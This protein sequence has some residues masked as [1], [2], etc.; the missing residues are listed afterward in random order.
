[1]GFACYHLQI[2]GDG[3][4]G[5]GFAQIVVC[6]EAHDWCVVVCL[7]AIGSVQRSWNPVRGQV[8]GVLGVGA[9]LL[10]LGTGIGGSRNG[11]GAIEGV[12]VRL[13]E[14]SGVDNRVNVLLHKGLLDLHY[15]VGIGELGEE[16]RG[17]EN[18]ERHPVSRDIEK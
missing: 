16:T 14:C 8:I 5:F 2:L 4:F 6:A 11:V 10:E 17:E 15:S 18:G 3:D 9:A 1:M 13:V 12:Q 7:A